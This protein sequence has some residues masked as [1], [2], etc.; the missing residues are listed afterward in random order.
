MKKIPLT[1]GKFALVDDEDFEELSKWNWFLNIGTNTNYAERKTNCKE[2][3]NGAKTS[4]RMHRF[5]MNPPKNM[6]VDHIDHNGLNNTKKNLRICTPSQN[7]MNTQLPSNN[8]SGFK[9]VHFHKRNKKWLAQIYVNKR[10]MYLGY[11]KS[12]EKAYKKYCDFA[13]LYYGEFANLPK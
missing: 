13:K 4:V 3:K 10:R 7:K 11:F 8:T 12:P 2:K 5:I 6:Q 1:R 9:G